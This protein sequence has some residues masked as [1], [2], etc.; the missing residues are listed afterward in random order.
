MPAGRWSQ[1]KMRRAKRK[2][3]AHVTKAE[4]VVTAE[5]NEVSLTIQA[6]ESRGWTCVGQARDGSGDWRLTLR[7][8]SSVKIETT[9]PAKSAGTLPGDSTLREPR[10]PR[11]RACDTPANFV[12]HRP[13]LA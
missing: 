11:L 9:D 10:Q 12:S 13:P 6:W 7:F 3:I 8:D 4:M 1:G 2:A 5:P